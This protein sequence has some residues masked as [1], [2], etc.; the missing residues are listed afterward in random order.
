MSLPPISNDA[1][2]SKFWIFRGVPRVLVQ[3]VLYEYDQIYEE[4]R[5]M[6][7]VFDVEVLA[8]TL[9]P[10]IVFVECV[11]DFHVLPVFFLEPLVYL[12]LILYHG[13]PIKICAR[14]IFCKKHP[15]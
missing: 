10:Q 11:L 13:K 4:V 14:M 1:M 9:R 12:P 3:N 8:L 2:V 15:H 7:S 5:E 6:G